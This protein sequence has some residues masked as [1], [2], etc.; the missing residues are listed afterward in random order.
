M[1]RFTNVFYFQK[2]SRF[3]FLGLVFML[4]SSVNA[5]ECTETVTVEGDDADNVAA[6]IDAFPCANGEEILAMTMDAI[7]GFNCPSWYS[8]DLYVNGALV[9]AGLCNE[10]GY[11]LS[12]FLPIT[13]VSIVSNDEDDYADGI[14]L[15][16]TLH[17]IYGELPEPPVTGCEY[18]V[19]LYD[20][21]GDGWNGGSLTVNVNGTGVLEDVTLDD[22][23]GPAVFT[24]F[25]ETDDDVE[26]VYSAGQYSYENEYY[27][28]DAFGE[29]VF[30]SGED[31]F[32]PVSGFIVADCGDCQYAV[33][34]YDTYGD[35]WNGGSL[36]VIVDGVTVL[37]GITLD[38]G[39]G[40]EFFNFTVFTDSDV[41]FVYTAGQYSG[42]NFYLV[43][44]AN[45]IEVFADGLGGATPAGGS[46]VGDCAAE[47]GTL[48]GVV[49]DAMT[50]EPIEGA[51]VTIEQGDDET[52]VTT[53]EDGIYE[54]ILPT[55]E[56]NVTASAP[57]Y[58]VGGLTETIVTITLDA[59]T[60]LDFELT[61]IMGADCSYPLV[62]EELP[63][64]ATGQTN[65]GFGNLYS[66]TC[67][68][69]YDGGEDIFYTF[70]I[71]EETTIDIVLDHKTTTYVG[72]ALFDA[73]PPPVSGC[74]ETA[75]NTSSGTIEILQVTL[76]AGTYFIMIDTWPLPNCVDDF[77]LV[78]RETPVGMMSGTV[79]GASSG[80]PLE[81]VMVTLTPGD[82]QTTTDASG[83]YEMEVFSG[84]YDATF[85]KP[86]YTEVVNSVEVPQDDTFI[87]DVEMEFEP[88]PVC[89][90][91]VAPADNEGNQTPDVLLQWEPSPLGGV[92]AG[93]RISIYNLSTDEWIA[94]DLDIGNVTSFAPDGGFEW[95]RQYVWL[96]IP[97][98]FEGEPQECNPW[99]FQT[100][101]SATLQGTV[102]DAQSGDP[103]ED[104]NVNI[105]GVFPD[106]AY[107]IDLTTDELGEWLNE[108]QAGIYNITFSKY[109]Y[110]DKSSNNVTVGNNQVVNLETELE[111]VTPYPI[112]FI[113]DWTSGSFATQQWSREGN[114]ELVP[115]GFTGLGPAARF[116]WA[117]RLFD[118]DF[119]LTSYIIDGR[120]QESVYLQFLIALLEDS[121]FQN[122]FNIDVFVFDG[123]EVHEVFSLDN[124]NGDLIGYATAD[125]SDIAA[126]KL[127]QIGFNANGVDTYAISTILLDNIFVTNQLFE[128]EPEKIS[129]ALFFD[130]TSTHSIEMFNYGLAGLSYTAEIV[131]P[132]PW[133]TLDQESGV[134]F[135]GISS[136]GLTF[137]ATGLA[138]GTYTA[139]VKIT[140]QGGLFEEYVQLE[141]QKFDEL[142]QKI[143]IPEAGNWGYIS[144]HIDVN[145]KASLDDLFAGIIDEMVILLGKEGF[146]WPEF[147]INTIG[148]YNNA[149]GYKIKMDE[150]T[151]LVFTGTPVE[152]KTLEVD[153]GTHIIP[154]LSEEPIATATL[155]E[156]KPVVFAY[157]LNGSIY[158]PAA[159]I[160]D[161][162]VL[163]PGYGYLAKFS[164]PTTLDFAAK[165]SAV[166]NKPV[167]FEN[168]TT[169]N[170]VTNTGQVHIVGV[171]AQAAGELV[172]G[173]YIGVFNLNNLCVGMA[174]Y[175][176]NSTPFAISVFA[177][178]M[179]TSEIDGMT[180]GE[181]L[182][183][184]IFRD[185][186]A[187]ET[188]V[189]FD[190]NLPNANG[191]FAENG[192]SMIESFKGA[193]SVSENPAASIRVY[194]N[195]S[196][197]VFNLTGMTGTYEMVVTNSQGQ[198]V[199]TTIVDE[200]QQL[201]LSTNPDGIY[202]IRMVNDQGVK[203]LKIIKN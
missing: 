106:P 157:S 58:E 31:D 171:S 120:D 131:S 77:D 176:G 11:D 79:T 33:E 43:Y 190:A 195:P 89:A 133:V 160:F 18:T 1:K 71:T 9:E 52:I 143:M 134:V 104:V 196:N 142:G 83:A 183:F 145:T 47:T 147:D 99:F 188:D 21:Y 44:D 8:Y 81:G 153:A 7:I 92:P 124:S 23:F 136:L 65:C 36:D 38:D 111:P 119:D 137:D 109:G 140:V 114:W 152:G 63:Y 32:T 66:N 180:A 19:E 198:V 156:E 117:P 62:I 97:Y 158:W 35:G 95:G 80:L 50:N 163:E 96:V 42:E 174:Q 94:E 70:T 45:G 112:P 4:Y 197:G 184:R 144:T 64:E 100:S 122:L 87:L 103:L 40:P 168:N 74:I 5:A 90:D 68:G 37:D 46:I 199:M 78:V 159:G 51:E 110:F 14:T 107:S 105:Q 93:Y 121:F 17:I 172:E 182:V 128:V 162:E 189:Y 154:V 170:D 69:N 194:P 26:F 118:Y 126:G 10:T 173:D 41:Q 27:V 98:N 130:E 202:F 48:A 60:T 115:S 15:T 123:E 12:E 166:A 16:L 191:L 55:G 57:G 39:F 73:C 203:L 102:T 82:Y 101:F 75:T 146:F 125:I 181:P 49:T 161:L 151:S 113:E 138:A 25:A 84:A 201:D 85:S 179:T 165:A 20:S 167:A 2:F 24:F 108:W 135:P 29:L 86:G 186:E 116:H 30:S 139:E 178:D 54:I 169:W 193:T 177:D 185:G 59:V 91:L 61:P 22:D 28:Y 88:A 149:E 150:T 187:L 200:A 132:A 141:L 76:Q 13:S 67:L 3:I 127:F 72:I 164:A 56:Y 129:D 6:T 148:A 175:H 34:L 155:F 192:L 53:D